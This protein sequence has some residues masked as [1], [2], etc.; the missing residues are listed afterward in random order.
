MNI[1][2]VDNK[3]LRLIGQAASTRSFAAGPLTAAST[4]VS[5]RSFRPISLT[6]WPT[7]SR[8]GLEIAPGVGPDLPLS[9]HVPCFVMLDDVSFTMKIVYISRATL[10]SE[11][12]WTPLDLG[13]GS[14]A[15]APN[16]S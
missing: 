6:R 7:K 9:E 8:E 10:D 3:T 13:M 11:R 14:I 1:V 5:F 15:W 12:H 2:S 4:R 16:P